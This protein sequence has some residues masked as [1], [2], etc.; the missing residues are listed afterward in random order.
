MSDLNRLTPAILF[1]MLCAAG[2]LAAGAPADIDT[3]DCPPIA[4]VKRPHFDRPFGIGT[5]IG[6]D[7]YKPGGGIYIYDPAEPGSGA[8]E[9]FRRD[10]GVIFDM[11]PS[12]DAKKLL[13]A[14]RK[15]THRNN[16]KGPLT[17]SRVWTDDTLDYIME[18]SEPLNSGQKPNHSFWD[19][20]GQTEWAEV[21]FTS[22]LQ[23]SRISV[24]WFDDKPTG[25]CAVPQSWRLFYRADAEW[26]PVRALTE[27]AVAKNA[28]NPL[29]FEPVQTKG[30]RIELQSRPGQGS[31]IQRLRI[32]DS[33][34]HQSILRL[35][36]EEAEQQDQDCFHIYEIATDGTGLRKIT[37]GPFQDIHPFYLPD[38]KIGFVSTR[39]RAF[40]LCQPGP[41]CALYV[42]DPDGRN[43]RRIH[44]GT[45]ADHSPCILD[46][47][48]ILFTRWEY[49]DKDLT[50]LQGL[51]TIDPAGKRVQL[52]FGNTILEPAVI[53]QAKP[54]PGTADVLCTLA[55]HHANPVGAVGIID[56]SQGLENP[57]GITNLTPEVDYNPERNARGPGDR[58]FP[59]AYRDPYPVSEDLFV[60]SYGGGGG[61]RRYRLFLMDRTGRK[62][63]LY[64]DDTISC[65]NPVPLI[66][67]KEPLTVYSEPPADEDFGT[68]FVADIYQ[69]LTGVQR[70]DVKA[71]RIMKVIPKP[72]NMR[73]QRGYDMDPVM[74][75]GT[76][77]GKYCLGTIPVSEDGSAYFKAPA[78]AELYFQ[79]LDAEGREL[80]RMGS[81]TQVVPGEVQSCIGCHESRFTAPPSRALST[82]AIAAE[83][84]DITPPPWGAEPMDF[85]RHIQPVFDKYCAKCHSGPDPK[86]GLDLSGDKTR[87]FNMAYD[88]LTQR[89]LVNFYWLLDEALVRAFLPLESGSLV[90]PLAQVIRESH[91]EV[92][93]ESRRRIYTWIEA[94]VPYYGTYDHT[95]P[96]TAG[97]RDAVVGT[98]WFDRLHSV[99]RRRCSSCHGDFY[100]QNKG[101]HHTWINLTHPAWSRLLN[102]PLP[103]A[104]GGLELCAPKEG[105]KPL[106]FTA[107]TD[108]DYETMLAAIRQGK[109]E[110]Y[111]KPRMDMPGAKP[112]PYP[113][114][115][116][117]PY[118]RFSGP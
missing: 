60:V 64:E 101:D 81:V 96:G 114:N 52:F 22:P 108:P 10:D 92:D 76:Y 88:S 49:Q 97:S 24:Y 23:I 39:V 99:Y 58:S 66:P 14:W 102:A 65:F 71:I 59:W 25:G 33:D 42:M 55:P 61:P 36:A 5:I 87:F 115:Y 113:K 72:C 46:N 17:V 69:G 117:G 13:F 80:C 6:W 7:I 106:L 2:A 70:G 100:T 8:R 107:K 74:S 27:Y 62:K 26:R 98:Q 90:S 45:L 118:T 32:G 41:A 9:I 47:G 83:P 40:A 31:G 38:G 18:L 53:W 109:E 51:W 112:V 30:L 56:R 63:I 16:K 86:A 111:A 110:L 116:A 48:Q 89:R 19:R 104:A 54:I 77:Y 4:F 82:R 94:N 12:F 75:R 44:F 103:K 57:L 95:R 15:C 78:G 11:S 21:N 3:A 84:V 1:L 73:G 43:I 91:P 35:A 29:R 28:W 67:R 34:Q 50:Y 37:E 105:R 79:A 93:D 85:V 68:F 20:K